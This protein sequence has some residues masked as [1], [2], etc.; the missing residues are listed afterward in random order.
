MHHPDDH[1][2]Q[3]GHRARH[4]DEGHRTHRRHRRNHR[5]RQGRHPDAGRHN[6]HRLRH[7]D[8]DHRTHRHPDEHLVRQ[9]DHRGHPGARH[10]DD[11]LERRDRR[12]PGVAEWACPTSI[13]VEA[14]WACP[15]PNA[16][17]WADVGRAHLAGE[18]RSGFPWEGVEAHHSASGDGAA[19]PREAACA[20]PEAEAKGAPEAE[21]A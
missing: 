12:P 6:R 14:E 7:Q 1:R 13:E 21:Q 5:H 3:E 16:E 4:Q 9:V 10:Q 20:G 8:A 17:A 2:P 19:A 11:R 18:G 15:F